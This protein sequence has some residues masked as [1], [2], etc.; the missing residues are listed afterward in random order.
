MIKNKIS[1][2]LITCL[3][4][5]ITIEI[6]SQDYCKSI[7]Y[8]CKDICCGCLYNNNKKSEEELKEELEEE[9]SN[10]TKEQERYFDDL[11]ED[12][13][14]NIRNF[15]DS[16][17]SENSDSTDAEYTIVKDGPKWKDGILG[18]G[19][20]GTVYKVKNK[21]GKIFALKKAFVKEKYSFTWKNEIQ[22]L[23]KCRKCKNVIKI[24]DVYKKKEI[25]KKYIV[26][27]NGEVKGFYYYII[28]EL[29]D[30]GDL[31]DIRSI[32]N[33]K[34]HNIKR[35]YIILRRIIYQMINAVKQVHDKGIIHRDIS[36]QNFF[37]GKDYNLYLGDFGCATEQYDGRCAG[38]HL[39][40]C[41][42]LQL[43]LNKKGN[44]L[45]QNENF[46]KLY[47]FLDIFAL[48]TSILHLLT[49][50]LWGA[51]ITYDDLINEN[52]TADEKWKKIKD[53][54]VENDISEKLS[55][56]RYTNTKC[57]DNEDVDFNKLQE[58]EKYKNLDSNFVNILI[59]KVFLESNIKTFDV[60][61]IDDFTNSDFYKEL[62]SLVTEEK[63]LA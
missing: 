9:E 54:I 1:L 52:I 19:A 41:V 62:E 63:N 34:S 4:H 47:K 30:H 43:Y 17:F 13:D 39:Y 44:E 10:L 51:L 56:F 37:I 3:M 50:L 48:S 23:I 59:K 35:Y 14:N 7:C 40:S 25:E 12:F 32:D 42:H 18:K 55:I 38:N 6:F 2:L 45:K 22:A 15:N 36:L 11:L 61:T 29:Y 46:N 57:K 8:C 16:I 60:V 5:I 31:S 26:E 24:V 27:D 53:K 33:I 58:P 49:G 20:Y 21:E 28:T